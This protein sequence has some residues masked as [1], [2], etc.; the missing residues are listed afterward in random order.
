MSAPLHTV[1]CNAHVRI[2]ARLALSRESPDWRP[3]TGSEPMDAGKQL[4][5]KQAH[6][7]VEL[8]PARQRRSRH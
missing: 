5:E 7:G 8:S 2:H 4:G 3:C 1:I 6:A